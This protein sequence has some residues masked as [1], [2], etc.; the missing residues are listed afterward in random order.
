MAEEE[1]FIKEDYLADWGEGHLGW[2]RIEILGGWHK[3]IMFY[4][5]SGIDLAFKL[6]YMLEEFTL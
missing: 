4:N 5:Y 3:G 1:Y 2:N 6:V